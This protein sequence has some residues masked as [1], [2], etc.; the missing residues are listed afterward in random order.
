MNR[1]FISR[2][3]VWI[4]NSCQSELCDP[5]FYVGRCAEH[6]NIKNGQTR[7]ERISILPIGLRLSLQEEKFDTG[8]GKIPSIVEIL[9]SNGVDIP[10]CAKSVADIKNSLFAR[11][12]CGYF[13]VR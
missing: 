7:L 9:P 5:L 11:C 3:R 4:L 2:L 10:S 12:T 13:N 6:H 8:S 1:V